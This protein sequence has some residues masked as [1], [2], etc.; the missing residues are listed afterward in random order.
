MELKQII[1]RNKYLVFITV[2][3]L[4]MN[5]W[6]Q[7]AHKFSSGYVRV[8]LFSSQNQQNFFTLFL[9]LS[10]FFFTFWLHHAAQI[11]DEGSNPPPLQWKCGILTAGPPRKSHMVRLQDSSLCQ[12]G[13]GSRDPSE[14]TKN[15]WSLGGLQP[16]SSVMPEL[17]MFCCDYSL[18][19]SGWLR[20]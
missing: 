19:W 6:R 14:Q 3:I 17:H 13:N 7:L 12:V 4:P 18:F 1:W 2:L 20:D 8:L 5:T 10:C 16:C 15:N 9:E 11:L